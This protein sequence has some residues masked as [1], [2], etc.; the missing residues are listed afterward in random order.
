MFSQW[1]GL[2]VV[3]PNVY[4]Y[5]R[6]K[7]GFSL[8]ASLMDNEGNK[9]SDDHVSRY[10]GLVSARMLA[11]F[12]KIT[13]SMMMI[14]RLGGSPPWKLRLWPQRSHKSILMHVLEAG[15]VSPECLLLC[16]VSWY[17]PQSTETVNV[18][19]G[20]IGYCPEGGYSL[21]PTIPD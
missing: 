9:F 17:T 5:S 15:S 16:R 11:G 7:Y 1:V 6:S 2:T 19:E 8:T 13:S 14:Q 3:R 4:D 20:L 12:R 18:R 21:R 10:I